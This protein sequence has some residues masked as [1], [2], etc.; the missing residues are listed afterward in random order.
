MQVRL[1]VGFGARN[2]LRRSCVS[3][4]RNAGEIAFYCMLGRLRAR[5]WLIYIYIFIVF[6]AQNAGKAF[7]FLRSLVENTRLSRFH[8][9]FLR[10]SHAKRSF[11]KPRYQAFLFFTTVFCGNCSYNIVIVYLFDGMSA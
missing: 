3:R 9:H 10:M 6:A 7:Q 11:W 4:V 2:P 1:R 8:S 5:Q